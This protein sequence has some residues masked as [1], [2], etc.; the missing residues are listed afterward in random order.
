MKLAW[1]V[2]AWALI[3]RMVIWTAEATLRLWS[4]WKFVRGLKAPSD[5]Q[6]DKCREIELNVQRGMLTTIKR[7]GGNYPKL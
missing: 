2:M 5:Q 3:A 4:N 6:H 1:A 7:S